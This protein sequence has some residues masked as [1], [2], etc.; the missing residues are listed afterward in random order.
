MSA[1]TLDSKLDLESPEA[2]ARAAHNR[3]LAEELRAKVAEAA[4]GGS[5][6]SRERHVSR[7]KLLPRER[8]ERLLDPGS[9][10]LEI[11]Q[12]AANGMYEGD[13][14]G[15]L[16]DRRHRPRLGPAGDDRRQRCDGEGRQL[17]P[18]DGQEAP[19]RAG[20]RSGE[21][22]AVHLPRRQRRGQP[23]LPGR[24]V[25]RPRPFRAHL[26]QPGA[27]ERRAHSADRLRHGQLHRG[28][29]LRP[30]DERRERD[31]ARAGHD[32]P[33]RAAAGEG[34]D[35]RGDQRRGPWAAATSMRRNRAWSITSPRTTSMR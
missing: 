2:K 28:R 32:L 25:P 13:V 9:P 23:A 1:P 14:A 4:L 26:L 34:R 18:D 8:V 16:D 11:G 21:P 6:K 33:R 17:L 19:A 5:E 15:R 31:R 10:F 20:D 27:D 35:G 22:A 12:L 30:G 24:G 3:A 7:G 29:R